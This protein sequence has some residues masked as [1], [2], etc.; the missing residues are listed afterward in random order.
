MSALQD[1]KD[2]IRYT[3]PLN[4][5]AIVRL[6]LYMNRCD[7]EMT[8]TTRLFQQHVWQLIFSFLYLNEYHG[9]YCFLYLNPDTYVFEI[10]ESDY[11]LPQNIIWELVD[12]FESTASTFIN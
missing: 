5:G 4:H 12:S 10:D 9:G 11:Y 3:P 2:A 6:K 8:D 7:N 1:Y